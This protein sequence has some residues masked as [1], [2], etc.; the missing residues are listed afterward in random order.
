MKKPV[1]GG[2]KLGQLQTRLYVQPQKMVRGLKFPIKEVAG[3]HF[4]LCSKNKGADQLC[5][6]RTD[7]LP[8]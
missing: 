5:I 4:Y 6:Y 7:D 2:F 1:L 3:I 8:L